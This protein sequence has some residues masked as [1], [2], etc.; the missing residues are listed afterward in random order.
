MASAVDVTSP[1]LDD[2][3]GLVL[4]P[5]PGTIGIVLAALAVG[6][7]LEGPVVTVVAGS[8]AGAGLLDWW[9]V[10]LVAVLA[11]VVSD[12]VFYLLGRGGARP[13][14][15]PLLVRLGLTTRRREALRDRVD[16]NL[17]QVVIGAKV[18]DVGAIPAF[19]A[20]GLAGVSYHRFLAWAV[21]AAAVRTAVLVGI[22]GWVGG[23]FASEL[24]DRPWIIVA[25][26]AGTG[27]VLMAGRALWMRVAASRKE[28]VCAS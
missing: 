14:L 3:L 20:I 6:V 21:P 28:N 5:G 4:Q 9:A 27:L 11:D 15:A 23:R 13:R 1:V 22:G 2:V 8:L 17:G 26:G 19:L 24:A 12:T 25:V 16:E 10:W 7:V 18:V